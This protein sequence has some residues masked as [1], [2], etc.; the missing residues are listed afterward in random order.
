MPKWEY[1]TVTRRR[2]YSSWGFGVS[3]W[4]IDLD[5]V[6]R[7][8]GEEGWGLGGAVARSGKPPGPLLSGVT[9]EEVW[10]FKRP[11]ADG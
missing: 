6:L 5:T 4:D 8:L 11:V 1:R 10:V 9:N 7:R 3:E 2:K